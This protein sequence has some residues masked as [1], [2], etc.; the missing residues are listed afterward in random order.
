MQHV[1]R[2]LTVLRNRN[3]TTLW[4]SQVFSA[5][6]DRFHEI[7]IV[8]YS[9]QLI[10]SEAGFI[11]A[12]GS[13][14]RLVLG[15]FGGVFADR[16]ER[17]RTLVVVDILRGAA[18]ATLP[19]AAIFGQITL[20][21]LAGVALVVGGLS[22]LFEPAL[23]ASLPG[24]A[25]DSQNLQAANALMDVTSRLARVFA[26]GLAGLVILWI[27]LEQFFSIDAL[28]FFV[29]AL[30]I[31]ALAAAFPRRPAAPAGQSYAPRQIFTEIWG[32]LRLVYAN[33][34]VFWG[35]IGMTVM[36]LA[37]SAAFTVGAALY[38]EQVLHASVGAY[39]L[40]VAAYGVG[41]VISNLVVGSLEVRNRARFLFI[42]KIIVGLGFLILSA[43][44]SLP[45]AMACMAF[46]A[47]GGPMGD[48]M[49]LLMIQEDFPAD[50]I[51]KVYST[52]MTLSSAGAALGLTLAGP[53]FKLL[54]VHTGIAVCA[55]LM[56][57]TGVAGTIAFFHTRQPALAQG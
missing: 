30:A 1:P 40:I 19:L 53:L 55:A 6:G 47:T 5:F 15:L 43:V 31:A 12:G 26:P 45:A 49:I 20:L 13:I 35:L 2:S 27:P 29:S 46:A 7:A 14:A 50:Q 25:G 48:I 41:N 54:D 34:P 28:T 36:S 57:T 10:G 18:V 51:G 37:W 8:W 4:L 52:L 44:S 33:A 16:W 24:L 17:H 56:L 22:A 3:I 42:G 9:I 32:A 38:A 39:G 11:L 21:H 23:Q